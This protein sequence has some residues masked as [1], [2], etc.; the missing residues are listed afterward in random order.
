MNFYQITLGGL[1]VDQNEV[2]DAIR[3]LGGESIQTSSGL[4]CAVDAPLDT[5]PEGLKIEKVDP[6]SSEST[7][8]SDMQNL[9]SK[10]A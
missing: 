7:L 6:K 5:L 9:I 10:Y 1:T 2:I 8:S 3:Q 4:F